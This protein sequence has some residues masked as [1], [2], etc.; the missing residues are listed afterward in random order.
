MTKVQ[1]RRD[2]DESV[3]TKCECR[4]EGADR[5]EDAVTKVQE[6]RNDGQA[7]GYTLPART[8]P[9]ETALNE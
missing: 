6:H 9:P 7:S 5:N 4:Y 3:G 1:G 2:G 8:S